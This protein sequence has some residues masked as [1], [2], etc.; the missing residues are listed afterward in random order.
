MAN[1]DLRP[2][3]A[4]WLEYRDVEIVEDDATGET[5]LKIEVRGKRGVGY[6]KCT[7]GPVRPCQWKVERNQ[8]ERTGQA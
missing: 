5:I 1:T 6:C 3:K 8:P 2:D 4:N 7:T